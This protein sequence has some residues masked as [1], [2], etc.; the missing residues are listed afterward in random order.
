MKLVTRDVIGT[1]WREMTK[2]LSH[3]SNRGWYRNRLSMSLSSLINVVTLN[4]PASLLQGISA[5]EGERDLFQLKRTLTD[6]SHRIRE[7]SHNL[8]I[9]Y[10]KYESSKQW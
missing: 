6:V 9:K 1:F 3:N 8:K 4:E 7:L 2:I 5:V 10:E